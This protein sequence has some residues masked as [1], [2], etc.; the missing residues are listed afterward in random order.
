VLECL[1]A[2]ADMVSAM[3]RSLWDN[4]SNGEFTPVWVSF[5]APG[6]AVKAAEEF[7]PAWLRPAWQWAKRNCG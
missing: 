7:I 6:A 5:F 2:F 3:N 1:N 4:L